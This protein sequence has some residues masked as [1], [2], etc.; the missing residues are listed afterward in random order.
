MNIEV[1][2]PLNRDQHTVS[3]VV[4]Q[5]FSV[6]HRLRDPQAGALTGLVIVAPAALRHENL[7]IKPASASRFRKYD[8]RGPLYTGPM[9]V[10]VG[11]AP[12]PTEQLHVGNVRTALYNWL[13]RP[14]GNACGRH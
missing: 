10:R 3:T 4:P 6:L 11:F 2:V 1:V 12:S 5:S 9:T 14:Q 8:Q 7:C 13:S